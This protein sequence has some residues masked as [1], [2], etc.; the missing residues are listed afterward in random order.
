MP[1]L[2]VL[3]V[4]ACAAAPAPSPETRLRLAAQGFEV[5]GSGLEIGFGRAPEGAEAAVSRL[6]GRAPS[7]R[8]VRGDCTAVRWAGGLEMRFRDRAFVG[9]HATPGKLALRTAAGVAPGGPRLPLPDGMRARA[10]PD[11]RIAALT[12]GADCV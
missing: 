2:A 6:L 5:A 4:A 3:G 12:A 1:G 7:D 11:G 10:A 9:W 8:I